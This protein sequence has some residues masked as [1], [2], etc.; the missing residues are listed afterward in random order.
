MDAAQADACARD[1]HTITN[2]KK[3]NHH[4]TDDCFG[5]IEGFLSTV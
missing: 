3:S 2:Q 5:I 1:V 4:F